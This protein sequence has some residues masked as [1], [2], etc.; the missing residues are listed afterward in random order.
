MVV[1]QLASR[2][3]SHLPVAGV[4]MAENGRQKIRPPSGTLRPDY[5]V[6]DDRLCWHDSRTCAQHPAFFG[7]AHHVDHNEQAPF[8]TDV[9]AVYWEDDATANDRN[10]VDR[11]SGSADQ[12][13]AGTR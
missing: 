4:D 13:A 5:P 12:C 1:A 7:C 9:K 11:V 6:G 8:V 2:T 10:R 3:S